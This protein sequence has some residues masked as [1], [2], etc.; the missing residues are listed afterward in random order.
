M[1]TDV[2]T[3]PAG[4]ELD[5]RLAVALGDYQPDAIKWLNDAEMMAYF[6]DTDLGQT[7]VG[8]EWYSTDVSAAFRLVAKL[9]ARGLCLSLSQQSDG[10]WR[11]ELE[12]PA[13]ATNN[14]AGMG[15]ADTPTL[16]ICRAAMQAIRETI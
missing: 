5:L 6:S 1:T 10:L 8:P 13:V 4:R 11:A 3:M 12:R 16:A 7:G 2:A 15:L 9:H 14:H